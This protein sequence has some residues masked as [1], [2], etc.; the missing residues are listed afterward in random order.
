MLAMALPFLVVYLLDRS[1]KWALIPFAAIAVVGMIPLLS[2]QFQDQNVGAIIT[3]LIGAPFLVVYLWNTRNWWALIPAGFMITIAIGVFISG[4]ALAGQA[5]LG[6]NETLGRLVGGVLFLGWALTFFLL[7][8]R[9][10]AAPTAWAVYP[11]AVLALF[12]L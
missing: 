7:W 10:A 6:E 9:R 5:G 2:T 11:A 1:R 12:A 4:S 3:L 8:L